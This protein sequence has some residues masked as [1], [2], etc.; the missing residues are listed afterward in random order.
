M[1]EPPTGRAYLRLILLG[2]AIGIP[3]ALVAALFLAA[4]HWLEHWLWGEGE[5]P[6]YAVVS[7]PVLGAVIVVL[8]RRFL[9]GDGGHSPL[10]GL[11]TSP[12]PVAYAPG[13]ILAALGSLSYGAV[14]GPE[15]PVIALGSVVGMTV[16]HFVKLDKQGTAVLSNAGEFSAISA[17]FGG[18]LVAGMLLVEGGIGLGARLLPVLLPGL[19]AAAIGY[20]IFIGF[21]SWGGL[22]A[23]GLVVPDL[24]AY[25]GVHVG[26]LL[27]VIVAGVLSAFV[28]AWVRQLGLRV[29]TVKLPMPALLP[30]G[31]LAVG[32]LALLA[33]ALGANSQDVLFSGQASVGVVATAD[34]TKIVL[35]LLATK[36]LA[37]AVCLGCGF[38]GGPIFPAVFL[39][40]AIA[41]LGVVWFDA[42]PTLALAAGAGAGMAAQTR[43]IFSPLLF[44]GLLV[45]ASS[46]DAIPPAVL[47]VAA[48]WLTTKFL[49]RRAQPTVETVAPAD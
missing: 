20:L 44:A 34:S 19:V 8:A 3:A 18:P 38:R 2:A 9:P 4:V 48:A 16:T 45:G 31:G 30:A 22:N 49:D 25:T 32:L 40:V 10:E 21:G 37:Y 41:S 17:L 5:P 11:S 33:R 27:I 29:S 47:A 43:L 35:I 1:A 13:V 26:E 24:P 23:P 7:L 42:S 6:W 12:T 14:L 15:A 39:G 46:L 28:V 36:F